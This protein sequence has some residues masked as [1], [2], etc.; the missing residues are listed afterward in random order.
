V[1]EHIERD[2]EALAEWRS[3]MPDGGT[4]LLSVPAHMA[5]WNP[6]DVWAGHFRRYERDAL[7]DLLRGT[8]FEP[9][10]VECYGFPLATLSEKLTAGRYARAGTR[11]DDSTVEGKRANSDR[12][13]IDR[14]HVMKWFPLIDNPLGKA[15]IGMAELAQRPFLGTE[16]GNGYLVAARAR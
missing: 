5:K 13:G 2:R 10:A 1:L 4:L 12:S 16:L 11:G 3:W 9:F 6:S 14:G 15:A 8:G 7:V